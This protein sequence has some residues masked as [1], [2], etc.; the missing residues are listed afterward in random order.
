MFRLQGEKIMDF[1]ALDQ[2]SDSCSMFLTRCVQSLPGK[3]LDC[4]G[5]EVLRQ[6]HE[7]QARHDPDHYM[8]LSER[9]LVKLFP[10]EFVLRQHQ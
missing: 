5:L 8:T 6:Y 1:S 2:C 9:I 10:Q 4:R 7:E 3:C